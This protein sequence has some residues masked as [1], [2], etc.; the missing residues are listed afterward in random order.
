MARTDYYA[1]EP[2]DWVTSGSTRTPEEYPYSHSEYYLWRTFASGDA[3][4]EAYYTDR[5]RS[6]DAEKYT[7]ATA[8]K[9]TNWHSVPISK[10]AADEIVKAYFGSSYVCVGI[11]QSMNVS[12]GYPL[13]VFFVRRALS[14]DGGRS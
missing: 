12:N 10:V 3:T 7:A 5:M 6:W 13:G 14:Q 2:Y 8:N 4:V 9:M 1:R 11:A